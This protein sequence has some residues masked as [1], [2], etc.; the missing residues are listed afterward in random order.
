VPAW[1][2]SCFK[3]PFDV[4]SRICLGLQVSAVQDNSVCFYFPQPSFRM[5]KIPAIFTC[6]IVVQLPG[7]LSHLLLLATVTTGL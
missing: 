4:F 7:C 2:I 6:N 3:A 5:F 1:P